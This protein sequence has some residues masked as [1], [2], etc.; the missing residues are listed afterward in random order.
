MHHAFEVD[1]SWMREEG[2]STAEW[3]TERPS[4]S[5]ILQRDECLYCMG[6]AAEGVHEVVTGVLKSVVVHPDGREQVVGFHVPGDIVGYDAL[7]QSTRSCSVVALD[8]AGVRS[9]PPV[10]LGRQGAETAALADIVTGLFRDLQ[11]LTDQI[12]LERATTRQRVAAFLLH[13]ARDL[14]RQGCSERELV[15]PMNRRDLACFLGLAPETLCRALSV[16]RRR[17]LIGVERNVIHI[18]DSAGLQAEAAGN[19]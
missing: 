6:A 14:A 9:L 10:C 8:T 16:L 2:A 4:P 19:E 5:R 13:Q 12:Y 15:L 3:L 1:E 7:V 11:R 17:R 18:R